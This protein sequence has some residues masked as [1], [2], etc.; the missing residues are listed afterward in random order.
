MVAQCSP[1]QDAG[2][3][4][5]GSATVELV[6]SEFGDVVVVELL[7]L[8]VKELER[9]DVEDALGSNAGADADSSRTSDVIEVEDSDCGSSRL[10]ISRL[11]SSMAVGSRLQLAHTLPHCGQRWTCAKHCA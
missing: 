1:G 2:G 6:T 9:R 7:E 5:G 4:G 10:R 3:S 11:V 8:V